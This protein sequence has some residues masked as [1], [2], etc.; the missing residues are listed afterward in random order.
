MPQD[1]NWRF[2]NCGERCKNWHFSYTHYTYVLPMLAYDIFT[3]EEI[4]YTCTVDFAS[5]T[6]LSGTWDN[7]FSIFEWFRD[8]FLVISLILI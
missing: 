2:T 7:S 8:V 6:L 3:Y 4:S 1:S 5:P